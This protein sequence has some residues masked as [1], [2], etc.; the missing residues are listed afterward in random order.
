M[1]CSPLNVSWRFGGT[2]H[3]HHQGWRI[4]FNGLYGIIS[5][6]IE[7]FF[8]NIC[9][10]HIM[11]YWGRNTCVDTCWSHQLQA[12]HRPQLPLSQSSNA[13]TYP[14]SPVSLIN[15]PCCYSIRS[16]LSL[17]PWGGLSLMGGDTEIHITVRTSAEFCILL[18]TV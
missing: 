8:E 7:F 12:S 18:S 2:C 5:R 15:L 11:R 16:I 17:I 13:L 4:T 9:I 1:P 10:C 6:K 3:L 14:S